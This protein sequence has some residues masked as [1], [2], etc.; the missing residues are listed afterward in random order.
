MVIGLK[1]IESVKGEFNMNIDINGTTW[2]NGQSFRINVQL[3]DS[4]N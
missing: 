3:N 2:Y 4:R 1:F